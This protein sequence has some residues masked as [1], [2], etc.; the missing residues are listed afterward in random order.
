MP[1]SKDIQTAAQFFIRQLTQYSIDIPQKSLDLNELS[2]SAGLFIR[3]RLG[4]LNRH[5]GR[6]QGSSS[7]FPGRASGLLS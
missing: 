4:A 7:I 2:L 1:A 6:G 3:H 5:L